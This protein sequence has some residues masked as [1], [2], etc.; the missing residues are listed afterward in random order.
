MRNFL[1]RWA[2]RV[3]YRVLRVYWFVAR[4]P[5][6]G[7]KCVL[8]RGDDVLL[9]RHTYGD[10]R[11]WDLPGGNVK[12]G[13]SPVRAATREV[14]EELGIEVDGWT[15]LGDVL[16]RIDYRRDT[17]SCFRAAVASADVNIDPAEIEEARWFGF[18]HPP[19]RTGRYVR[20]ILALAR[21][22]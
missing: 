20:R 9:V 22:G 11:R 13:E 5:K 16:A 2:F 3:G 10:R 4:P 18:E 17:L 15:A 6:R 8:I 21:T 7:V 14:R 19:Q 1:L 12:R